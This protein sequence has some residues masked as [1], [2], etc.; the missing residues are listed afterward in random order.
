MDNDLSL[1]ADR[2][3]SS[4]VDDKFGL[5]EVADKLAGSVISSASKDGMVIGIEGKWGSGKT[6]LINLMMQKIDEGSKSNISTINFAPWLI[7]GPEDYIISLMNSLTDKVDAI[8]EQNGDTFNKIDKERLKSNLKKYGVRTIDILSYAS[9]LIEPS[10]AASKI[11]AYFSRVISAGTEKNSKFVSIDRRK[12]TIS[13]ILKKFDHRFVIVIDDLDRLEP[14][15]AVEVMRLIRSVADFPNVVYLIC[16]DR[17]I[18]A[19][20]I[21][22][23][24]NLEDGDDYLQKIVQVSFKVPTP[25]A[26]DLRYWLNKD[27]LDILSEQNSIRPTKK[28]LEDLY[29]V[30]DQFGTM[31]TPRDVVSILNSIKFHYPPVKDSVYF[32]DLVWLHLIK[33]LKPNLY[34]WCEK[35]LAEW[36]VISTGDARASGNDKLN[37]QLVKILADDLTSTDKYFLKRL[38]PGLSFEGDDT[39][40]LFGRIDNVTFETLVQ[41]SRLSSPDHWRYYFAFS[42]PKSSMTTSEINEVSNLAE[43]DLKKFQLKLIDL[44]KNKRQ[45]NGTWLEYY[46]DRIAISNFDDWST[47]KLSNVIFGICDEMDV[48]GNS[49]DIRVQM[50]RIQIK[51]KTVELI[52]KLLKILKSKKA[53]SFNTTINRVMKNA[54]SIGWLVDDFLN[55]ELR[56]HNIIPNKQYTNDP[57]I[58][59]KA[60]AKTAQKTLLSRLNQKID[61]DRLFN[62]NELASP[63]FRWRDIDNGSIEKP[64]KWFEEYTKTDDDF[65]YVLERMRG[66]SS[67]GEKITY[68]L[69]EDTISHLMEWEKCKERLLEISTNNKTSAASKRTALELIEATKVDDW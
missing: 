56:R 30:I 55:I 33:I 29:Q 16:Y 36:A 61:R 50:G 66:W 51:Y 68:P 54:K 15:E 60:Q 35:Y 31:Q 24:L 19:H 25:E 64:K 49:P 69:G 11:I 38:C 27:C 3:L 26:F 18:L 45:V 43:S 58:L 41:N 6:S 32:P 52:Y 67:S 42:S 7:G 53:S 59:S 40:N 37:V 46:F 1:S 44:S 57:N 13:E 48:I 14:K 9:A 20:A 28:S 8:S 22:E 63:L 12:K 62:N 21:K 39:I 5:S 65:L 47:R 23:G 34:N 4:S 17:E 2:S 10:G